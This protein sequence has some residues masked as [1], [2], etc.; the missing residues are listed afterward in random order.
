MRARTHRA[1]AI[2]A[3]LFRLLPASFPGERV[4]AADAGGSSPARSAALFEKMVPVL[5]HPRC[6]NCHSRAEFPRQGDDRH[7]HTMNVSRGPDDHGALALH[8]NT[9]HQ[10]A[11]QPASGVP[12]APDWHLAPIRMAWEGLSAGELCRALLDPR[13]GGMQP[14]KL[15]DHLNTGLVRWGWSPGTNAQGAPRTT[16]PLSHEA[17]VEVARQWAASGSH[18]PGG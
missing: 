16:P 1:F 12:G 3:C 2:L 5:M 8:C 15:V 9:C 7:R 14:G 18:C 11:N 10:A 6:L 4:F 13:R 17:F